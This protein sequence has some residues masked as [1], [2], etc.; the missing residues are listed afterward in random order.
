MKQVTLKVMTLT[1]FK[2]HKS[3]TVEF[4]NNTVI[5]GDNRLGKST[6]FDAFIWLLF[7]KDQFDR[8]DF[9]IIPIIDGKR[10]ERIDSEVETILIVDGREI[11]LKRVL[12]QKWVRRRGTADEVFDGC[13]TLF[14]WDDVPLKAGE[15]KARVDL[16][17]EET[18]FKLITNPAAFLAL[19]WTKQREFLF[20][21][22]GTISDKHIA[23]QNP[24][25]AA[26]L[27]AVNGKSFT[28]FKKELA[29]RKRKLQEELDNIGPRI[30][31]TT[32]LMPE[33]KDWASI[34]KE[35]AEI[36]EQ[37]AAIDKQ[38]SDRSAAIKGQYDEI[39]RKHEE[40][41][42][43]KTKQR[44]IV[45]KE[46]NKARESASNHNRS[47]SELQ[48]NV[49]NLTFKSKQAD[50]VRDQFAKK[51]ESL[52]RN[53][54][55]LEAE[56]SKLREDWQAENA[57]EYKSSN[58]CLI[59]PVFGSE[60]GDELAKEKHSTAQ[61]AAKISFSGAKQ[62]RLNEINRQGENKSEELAKINQSILEATQELEKATNEVLSIEKQL[63]EANELLENTPA[64]ASTPV[65]ASELPEWCAIKKQIEEIEATIQDVKHIDNSDLTMRKY[66][67]TIKRDELKK[68]LTDRDLISRYNNEIEELKNS[69]SNYAQ[70]IADIEKQ[71]FTI[72]EFTKVKIDECERRVNGLFNLVKFQLFDKT[73]DGNEF[74]ACIALNK[75]NVPISATNTA[76]QIN[77]GLDIIN[78][79]SN[80]YNVSAP[81][82]CDGAES[83]NNYAITGSQMIFLKVTKEPVLTI[84][85]N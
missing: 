32:K 8:K 34:E 82:F 63:K 44:E 70:Q 5:S 18:I 55:V 43:L 39:Q 48:N 53:Q 10:L 85:H 3:L 51:I 58:G 13:E 41:S 59:C 45:E 21:I 37:I 47:R 35:I 49:S 15:Y 81:I 57:K 22:A 29:A 31:Q 20:Q 9:E 50:I 40:I 76:E 38:L 2:G 66:E 16:L 42:T 52:K 14:F 23:S 79:L 65:V 24:N 17:V 78:T 68:Q 6:V 1:N 33:V 80:F 72:A 74:E 73:I 71:E 4:S 83:N 12:H 7:G 69:A 56:I 84:S 19:H 61:E 30:D 77:A 62:K 26:L 46:E 54:S 25:F 28:E 67:I 36:D 11:R 27:E 64:V 60:C 75:S